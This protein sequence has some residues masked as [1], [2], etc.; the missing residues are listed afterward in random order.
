MLKYCVK[1]LV[2]SL[3]VVWGVLTI[4]FIVMHLAP[5]DPTSV[6]VRPEIA[7]ETVLHI[8]EH[9]GLDQPLAAQYLSWLTSFVSGNFGTSF[10]HN[11]PVSR[12]LAEAIPNTLQLTT[13]VL[14]LHLIL[15]AALGVF[16]ALKHGSRAA[17]TL[18]A[19][20]MFLYSMPSF[21]LALMAIMFF[22]VKLGWLPSSQMSSFQAPES[23]Y[24]VFIDRIRH[25]ILPATVLTIPF[26]AYTARYIKDS[27]LKVLHEDYIRTAVAF[28]L[29]QRQILFKYAL[30]NALLPTITLLGFYLPFLLGG[31]VV[32]EHIFAWPGVGR[33]T[34][35]AIFANDFPVILA[36]TC[37]AA[38]AVVIGNQ[39]SD[40]L[41]YVVDP[42]IRIPDES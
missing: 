6:Y 22:S 15:G 18:N 31:A 10:T 1:R 40:L 20:L 25:M 8:R 35:N 24:D 16:M 39:L 36:S 12:L 5:G 38:V 23:L 7:P 30:R 19:V 27:M 26:A 9:L 17:S 37:L 4:T 28:G 42:R 34:I 33:I 14:I 2:S 13:V 41:Y 3:L 21:W 11:R 29:P 32:V